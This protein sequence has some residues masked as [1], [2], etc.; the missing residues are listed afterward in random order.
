[1]IAALKNWAEGLTDEVGEA[2]PV[3]RDIERNRLA[4]STSALL[5]KHA[6]ERERRKAGGSNCRWP[7]WRSF[8]AEHS[9]S[10]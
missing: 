8:P 2:C 9:R 4:G 7:V 3:L 6:S 1:V 10:L 5:A